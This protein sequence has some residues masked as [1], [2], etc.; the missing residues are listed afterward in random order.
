MVQANQ[1]PGGGDGPV[2][3]STQDDSVTML[4]AIAE[5]LSQLVEATGPPPTPTLTVSIAS[6]PAAATAGAGA[7]YVVNNHTGAVTFGVAPTAGGAIVVPVYST[8]VTW[9]MGSGGDKVGGNFRGGG[10]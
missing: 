3:G 8:G 6:L 7:R 5:N 10:G 2:S 4:R 9:L 1:F